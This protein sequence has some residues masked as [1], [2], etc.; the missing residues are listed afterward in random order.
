MNVSDVERINEL[1]NRAEIESA[2]S[3]GEIKSIKKE[4]VKKY[5]TDDIDEIKKKLLDLCNEL[6][7]TNERKELLR[8]KLLESYDWDSLEKEL[9]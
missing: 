9:G 5:G 1:I 7:K 2:K 3:E 8:K 6:D 4:W